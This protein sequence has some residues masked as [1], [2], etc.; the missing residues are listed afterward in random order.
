V[1]AT[2]DAS[3][4]HPIRAIVVPSATPGSDG[5]MTGADKAKLDAL[6]PVV[7]SAGGWLKG[8]LLIPDTATTGNWKVAPAGNTLTDP[9]AGDV[10]SPEPALG[11]N[12]MAVALSDV[13]AAQ[14][15]QI[16]FP[17]QIVQMRFDPGTVSP[18]GLNPVI[19]R[20]A[21]VRLAPG[22][23]AKGDGCVMSGGGS[24]S[25]V[26]RGQ[27]PAAIGFALQNASSG[28]GAW[29]VDGVN[30]AV[31]LVSVLFFPVA[32]EPNGTRLV[33]DRDTALNPAGI[34]FGQYSKIAVSSS[35]GTPAGNFQLQLP[36]N[37]IG[38][39][40]GAVIEIFDA[41]GTASAGAPITVIVTST[42]TLSGSSATIQTAYGG[43]RAFG[44][45]PNAGSGVTGWKLVAF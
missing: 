4:S 12:L 3:S 42:D 6:T 32:P 26:L 13:G 11:R 31:P 29:T 8:Q 22:S 41:D 2:I 44:K 36:S 18:L 25:D 39:Y 23:R 24:L 10:S 5:A 35:S 9:A 33:I 16:A 1:N 37:T 15:G 19:T 20:G 28:G 45:S 43:L 27:N 34:D 21:L 40:A 14:Q 17:G 38:R 30:V 7:T